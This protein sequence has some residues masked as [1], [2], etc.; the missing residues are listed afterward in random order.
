MPGSVISLPGFESLSYRL[1]TA[2]VFG[3]ERTS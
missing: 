2:S 1:Q 3:L